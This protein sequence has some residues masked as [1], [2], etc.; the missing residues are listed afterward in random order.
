MPE[1][2]GATVPPRRAKHQPGLWTRA[3]TAGGPNQAPRK[4]HGML[5][6]IEFMPV[7]IATMPLVTGL[8]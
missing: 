4:R 5:R 8:T 3:P 1:Q 6:W 7:T 2:S